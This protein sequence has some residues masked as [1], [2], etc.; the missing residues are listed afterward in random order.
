MK[1]TVAPIRPLGRPHPI[2]A[3]GFS[4]L[5]VLVAIVV[6]SFG[7]LGVVGLQAMAMQANKET[8][9]QSAAVVLGRELGDM[10]RGTKNI[11]I[12]TSAAQNPYLVDF[13][14]TLPAAAGDC[15]AAACVSPLT[16]AQFNMREWL[17]R[18]DQ[19]L[20]GARVVVCFDDAP[21]DASGRPRWACDG[22]A[23]GT[24]VVKIGWARQSANVN[25]TDL[26]RVTG[27]GATGVPSVILPLTAGST[28]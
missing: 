13:T 23:T 24:A 6:L 10:M 3:R 4:L 26:D 2:A 21:Y 7:V 9:Y 17:Q 1:I 11:A 12:D 18:V 20:P 28:Q 5:E 15:F 19:A 25:A 22:G 16:V 14:G 8:R 27:A